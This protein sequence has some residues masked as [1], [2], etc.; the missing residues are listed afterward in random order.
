MRSVSKN[1]AYYHV[2]CA[3]R[4]KEWPF[5]LLKSGSNRTQSL[6]SHETLDIDGILPA[7]V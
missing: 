2:G 4:D 1:E 5:P 3:D 6:H 7:D